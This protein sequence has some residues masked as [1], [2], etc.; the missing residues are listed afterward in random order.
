VEIVTEGDGIV[1]PRAFSEQEREI[2]RGKLLD[3]AEAFLSTTGIRKTTVEDLAKTAGISKGAFYLFYE[4]KEL[5]FMDALEREQMGI[6]NTL[7]QCMAQGP[8]P[9]DA[10]VHFA[11]EMYREYARKPWLLAFEGEDYALLLR[12][13][14]PERIQQ[15]IEIDNAATRRFK[16]ILGDEITVSPEL[17]SAAMRMLFIGILHRKEIGEE[18]AD[19]AFSLMLESLADRIFKEEI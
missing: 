18:W 5:L 9:R 12:R 2:V 15:H 11:G 3:A 7:L 13:V 14:S 1:S 8:S 6:H 16:D 19:E 17:M 10:F 4:S